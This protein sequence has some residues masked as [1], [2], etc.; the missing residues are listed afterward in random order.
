MNRPPKL[1]FVLG[2]PKSGTTWLQHLLDSHPEIR[3]TG[4]GALYRYLEGLARA[5]VDYNK[6][7]KRRYRLFET[8]TLPPIG[9][10]ELNRAFRF[11]ALQRLQAAVGADDVP[12]FLG[13][14]D[15]DFGHI[16][17]NLVRAFPRAAVIH[18][19]RDGRDRAVSSWH[20][21]RRDPPER[22]PKW[23]T[24]DFREMAL[25]MAPIWARYIRTV[26]TNINGS[27]MR[28]H[29]L[30]YEKLKE[31]TVGVMQGIFS[32]LGADSERAKTEACVAAAAFS[33]L[34]GGRSPGEEDTS[35]FYRKGV[36]GDWRNYFDAKTSAAFCRATNGLMKELGYEEDPDAAVASPGQDDTPLAR[37]SMTGV[38]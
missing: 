33:K 24:D 12:P 8:E 21:I 29:E 11:L 32:F 1:F 3:C 10:D 14:K 22:R 6:H 30:R 23:F 20:H 38:E 35:S 17:G 4:E 36:A 13:N 7:L 26:R 27:Q 31:E 9:D 28:Y 25:L 18:I 19:I 37:Q 16:I 5:V 2:V 34:S 15:P